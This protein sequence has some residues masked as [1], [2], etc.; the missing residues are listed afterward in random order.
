MKTSVMSAWRVQLCFTAVKT[1]SF[2]PTSYSA[3][4]WEHHNELPISKA[5]FNPN[6]L[7]KINLKQKLVIGQVERKQREF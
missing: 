5:V 4:T 1:F 3:A 2:F 7:V 6:V